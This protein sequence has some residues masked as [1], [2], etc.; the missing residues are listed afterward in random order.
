[1][2]NYNLCITVT[3]GGGSLPVFLFKSQGDT[4]TQPITINSIFADGYNVNFPTCG[5]PIG[6]IQNTS[7]VSFTPSSSTYSLPYTTI[8]GSWIFGNY[9]SITSLIINGIPITSNPQVIVNGA[10]TLTIYYAVCQTQNTFSCPIAPTPTSTT[11]PTTTPTNS[12]TPTKTITPTQTKT[13]TTTT[14]LTKTPTSTPI[15]C[16]SGVTT[17]SYFYIDCCGVQRSGVSVGET[18]L[19]DYGYAYT[20][21]IN[22]LFISSST[23]CPTPSSTATPTTTPSYSPTSTQT[24]TPSTTNFPSLTPTKTPQ[25]TPVY[26]LKNDC[27][28]FTLFDLGVSCNV[29]KQAS[30]GQ[31]DGILSLF[32]TGGTSPYQIYWNGVLGEQTKTGL[33]SGLYQVRVIDFYGDYTANTVC[34]LLAPTPT[35]TITPTVTNTPTPSGTYPNLCL[36]ALGQENYGPLQFVYGGTL[37]GKPYWKSGSQYNIV[38]KTYRWEVVGSDFNTPYQFNGGGIFVS[39]T[40]SIPPLAGWSVNGGTLPYNI[41]VTQGTCPPKLPLQATTTKTDSTCGGNSNCDGSITVF[42]QNGTPP[43]QYSVNNGVSWV[44]GNIFQGLCPN[45]YTVLTKDSVGSQITNVVTIG[46]SQNPQTYQV[47]ISLLPKVGQTITDD[48][49]SQKIRF[50]QIQTVPALPLGVTLNIV[51]NMTSLE[52][53]NGPGLGSIT[54]V[55]SITKN[56][57]SVLP[58]Q[59]T[60]NTS[61]S[62]RPNC[63]PE[64]Q[65]VSTVNSKYSFTL[66]ANDV[67]QIRSSSTLTITQGQIAPQTNCTTELINNVSAN[68][69]SAQINGCTCCSTSVDSNVFNLNSNQV[70][71]VEEDSP[72]TECVTI[73]VSLNQ[74]GSGCEGFTNVVIAMSPSPYNLDPLTFGNILAYRYPIATCQGTPSL[75]NQNLGITLPTGTA[76]RIECILS[77]WAGT[78]SY[79]ILSLV[80]NGTTYTNGQSFT[81][82]GKCYNIVF[83]GCNE[84]VPLP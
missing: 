11:T 34:S 82:N 67:I 76:S 66:S 50:A 52:T 43:Y 2:A 73:D 21:G 57:V 5:S 49:Y 79:Q 9:V 30:P 61:V 16:G 53:I 55:N 51:L 29:I 40:S 33:N 71:Y 13:P 27:D 42:A 74:G 58:T 19:L 17:G 48:N 3:N 25:P 68:I 37:N 78:Q 46:S 44:L 39:S 18:V 69:S 10:D 6:S 60:T 24:P 23:S 64:N 80:I 8:S 54:S 35:T 70:S 12:I 77:S 65:T 31:N 47:Q 41:S 26:K 45:T 56:S 28:T 59:S 14:T 1:M 84:D 7:S 81:L 22:K 75:F 15:I 20:T 62:N 63:S 4:P 83:Q 38:W 72:S 32:I 36:I